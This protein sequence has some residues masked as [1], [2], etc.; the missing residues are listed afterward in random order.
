[1]LKQAGL[2]LLAMQR[3]PWEQGVAIQAFLELREYDTVFALAK[4]AANRA[5]PDGR[6]A[7]ISVLNGVTDPCCTG[8]GLIFAAKHTGDPEIMSVCAELLK[9]A[10]ERA[11][12]NDDGLVYHISDKPQF[13]VDSMYMLPPYLAA[14]GYYDAA[15]HQLNG[16]W[17]LLYDDGKRL[18]RH[19]WDDGRKEYA[20]ADFWGVGN[21][22]TL[23]ALARIIDLLPED[24]QK[25]RGELVAKAGALIDSLLAYMRTDGFFHDVVDDS[26]SF[27]EVNLSQ[28]LC[29]SI[30]RAKKSGWAKPEWIPAAEKARFAVHAKIDRYGFVRDVCGAPSFD[31]PGTAPEGQAF[32][33]MMEAAFANL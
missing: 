19:I 30:F 12:R 23:A 6:P 1:M 32:F 14:A 33:L 2:A 27:V 3:N 4:E 24:M 28:M 31:K 7:M 21:G 22:W 29:Y 25:E 20:R 15:L 13:W 16:Y 11:P 10:L 5:I 18:M 17:E 26:G 9:W 8:E